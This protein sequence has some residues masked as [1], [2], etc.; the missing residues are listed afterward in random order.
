MVFK[1][2]WGGYERVSKLRRKKEY[3]RRDNSMCEEY[4]SGREYDILIMLVDVSIIKV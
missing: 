3:F 4:G 2:G 1:L